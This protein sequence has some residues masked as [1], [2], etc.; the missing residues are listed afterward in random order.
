MGIMLAII[1][2][3][4]FG[5]W[6][7]PSTSLKIDPKIKTFWLTIGHFTLSALVY[8]F[9]FQSFFFSQFAFPFVAGMFWGIGMLFGFIGIKHLGMARAFGIWTP[10][11][12]LVSATW[13]LFFFGEIETFTANNLIL[14]LF[15]ILLLIIAALA[16]IFSN[17]GEKKL[18]NVKVGILSALL[19][20]ILHGSY[21]I[22]L[23]T[24]TLSIF[25]TF[26]PLTLGMLLVS[27]L[28]IFTR[29]ISL[30]S[31]PF[32]ILRMIL[33]GV[34]LGAGNYT[35][36]L[37]IQYLGVSRGYPLTQLGIVVSTLWGIFFFKEVT[38]F[39]RKAFVTV[40]IFIAI[41]GAVLL[42]LARM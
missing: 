32:S 26:L 34:I 25:V 15:S 13:G 18:G 8:L 1:T 2:I 11:V 42:N 5:S 27:S 10:T 33:S 3:F 24:S 36:M 20:G 30:K 40:G 35:A 31:N 22:P 14:S 7:V 12:I 29:K 21:F 9:F 23:R 39:K 41:I 6:A 4:L 28:A 38:T 17:K 19:L 37:T 16:I